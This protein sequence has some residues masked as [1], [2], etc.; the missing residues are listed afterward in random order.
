MEYL[1]KSTNQKFDIITISE[2]RIKKNT[3]FTNN[4]NLV[5][6]CLEHT[7]TESHAGGTLLYINNKLSYKPRNDLNLYKS[8][9]L[10][11]TII[12]LI[13]PKKI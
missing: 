9:K 1:L 10:E 2:S 3:N 6:Y 7:P 13:N 11:S 4:I 12:E 5:D 8:Y